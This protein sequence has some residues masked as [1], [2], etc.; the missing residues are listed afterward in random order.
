[1][2]SARGYDGNCRPELP[3]PLPWIL[4][5]AFC[6]TYMYGRSH[7]KCRLM[8]LQFGLKGL[9]ALISNPVGGS[10]QAHGSICHSSPRPAKRYDCLPILTVE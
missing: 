3:Q 7:D 10:G 8:M 9:A 1:M 5:T 6:A 4:L 2:R